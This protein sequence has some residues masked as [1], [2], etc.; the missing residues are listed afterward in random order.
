MTN[1]LQKIGLY[2]FVKLF[3]THKRTF[4]DCIYTRFTRLLTKLAP[5]FN[6]FHYSICI[7]IDLTRHISI[8]FT[9]I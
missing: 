1:T 5:N 2:A 8:V 9:T 7:F 3:H 4:F 6:S